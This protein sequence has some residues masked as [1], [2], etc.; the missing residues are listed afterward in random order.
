MRPVDLLLRG[1][2]QALPLLQS[3]ALDD[4]WSEPSVLDA[5]SNG[6]LA[7]HLA[8]SAFNLQQ[9]LDRRLT[10]RATLNAVGYYATTPPEPPDSAIGRRIREL[11]DLE[12]AEGSAAL[13][14]R[15]ES[16]IDVLRAR[17]LSAD[18]TTVVEMLGRRLTVDDCATAC[19][20]ELVVHS[21][22][23]AVGLGVDPPDFEEPII[24][25][26]TVTLTRISR[27]RHGH[28]AVVCTLARSERAPEGGI[29]VF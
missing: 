28:A 7:G 12:A 3:R 1:C 4:R 18:V 10:T 11:G 5:W 19:L 6:G 16:S 17:D 2:E 25:H 15:F 8:R 13:A 29:S 21:D 20:L 23:L 26:V 14:A 27:A 24:D 22:D 9:A